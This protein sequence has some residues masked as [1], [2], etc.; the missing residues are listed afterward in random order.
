M[1]IKIKPIAWVKN[2]REK[3]EDDDWEN[4]ISEIE[5]DEEIPDSALQNIFSFSHLEII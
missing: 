2:N 3:P 5:L 1:D 4:I